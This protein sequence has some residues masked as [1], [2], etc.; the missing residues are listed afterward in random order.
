M[1]TEAR[2]FTGNYRFS[3]EGTTW[4]GYF[5]TDGDALEYASSSTD[6]AALPTVEKL[7][8]DQWCLY[9]MKHH[10]FVLHQAA[11]SRHGNIMQAVEFLADNG[12]MDSETAVLLREAIYNGFDRLVT[13]RLE[14]E[15]DMEISHAG[16]FPAYI[17]P[18]NVT[19]AQ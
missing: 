6:T 14:M 10:G 11:P 17:L 4:G 18:G 19:L 2:P 15:W 1:K 16:D 13:R 12:R 8:G 3:F 7:V 5:T 9:S